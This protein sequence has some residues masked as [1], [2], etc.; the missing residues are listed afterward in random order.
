MSDESRTIYRSVRLTEPGAAVCTGTA[1]CSGCGEGVWLEESHYE[2]AKARS[3]E[4]EI[5][6]RECVTP[7]I[8]EADEITSMDGRPI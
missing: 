4:I 8:E 1:V 6:C 3:P 5:L 7:L 2:W